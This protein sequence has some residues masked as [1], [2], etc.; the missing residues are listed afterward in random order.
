MRYTVSD[1]YQTFPYGLK[2]IAGSGGM[3][4]TIS[5]AGILDYEI[6][7]VLKDK[8]LHSNFH[9]NQLVVT[10]L[11]CVKDNPFLIAE[12][13]KHLI[14]KGT[15]GLVIKNVFRLPIHESILR[16]ADSKNFPII[17][18]ESQDVYMERVIYEISRH[19]ELLADVRFAQRILDQILS[20][21]LQD[22]E[23]VQ[24]LKQINPSC[25][26]QFFTIC[27]QFDD[28]LE[29]AAFD[30]YDRRFAESDLNRPGNLLVLR[31]DSLFYAHSAD[32][33]AKEY[34]DTLIRHILNVLLQGDPYLRCGVSQYHLTLQEF[35]MSL[36]ESIYAATADTS[37]G[38]AFI[39]YSQLGVHQFIFPFAGSREMMQYARDILEPIEDYDIE[40]NGHLL[41]TL[42]HFVRLDGDINAAADALCQHRNT[43]RY[44]LDKI[45]EL[46]GLDYKRFSHLEQL[47]IAL[48]IRQCGEKR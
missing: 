5:E 1:F 4:R 20:G 2:I 16:Y 36:Q 11:S 25:K 8:Y 26:D 17:L 30:T 23:I 14:A 3:A 13:V 40:N 41:D 27:I 48:K 44:R 47:S 10:T 33:I 45:G 29:N 12:A 21:D 7:V 9:E 39:K 32:R 38:S 6:D 19:C 22:E 37:E 31:E 43:I 42:S 24:K 46:T 18:I 35:K 34:S 28:Y 15:S